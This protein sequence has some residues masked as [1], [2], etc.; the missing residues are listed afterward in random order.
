MSPIFFILPLEVCEVA[1]GKQPQWQYCLWRSMHRLET[2]TVDFSSLWTHSIGQGLW[3]INLVVDSIIPTYVVL[4]N[5]WTHLVFKII[6]S[7]Q[8]VLTEHR[9]TGRSYANAKWTH[10][11][12]Q[13]VQMY[14]KIQTKPPIHNREEEISH[15]DR[16]I[17]L[18]C[19]HNHELNKSC[20]WQ[21]K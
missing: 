10:T 21:S 4:T 6:Y 11:E 9:E 2:G 13:W 18:G 16:T 20:A 14:N 3:L 15:I 8:L 1:V 17:T 7:Q 5:G 19:R 12:V